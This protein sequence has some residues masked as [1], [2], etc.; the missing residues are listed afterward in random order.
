MI[1]TYLFK[2]K[3]SQKDYIIQGIDLL[4]DLILESMEQL[5]NGISYNDTE[6][7]QMEILPNCYR[8]RY[9]VNFL[10]QFFDVILAIIYKLNDLDFIWLL[11]SVAEEIAMNAILDEAIV[12]AEINEKNI[13]FDDLYTRFFED[14][15]YE[16]LF[17]TH[18]DGLQDD[19]EFTEANQIINLKFD[20]WF[21]PFKIGFACRKKINKPENVNSETDDFL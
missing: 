20:D 16:I 10:K 19:E 14:A 17:A 12:V 3:K 6:M 15:D 8:H 21:K 9:D 2:L 4:T 5:E 7:G 18:L 11:N 13:D 1:G